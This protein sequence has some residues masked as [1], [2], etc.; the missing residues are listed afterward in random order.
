[1]LFYAALG[2][3]V[4]VSIRAVGALLTFTMLVAPGAAALSLTQRLSRAFALATVLGVVSSVAGVALS[5]Q[6]DL[7]TGST[8]VAVLTALFV[9]A[10]ALGRL[11]EA[12]A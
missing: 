7:P 5:Y 8:I 9:A 2:V 3:A 1:M 6:Y 12:G 4:A 11:R 10:L